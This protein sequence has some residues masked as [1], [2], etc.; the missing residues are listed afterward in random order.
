MT[1][2]IRQSF[3]WFTALESAALMP[4]RRN[5]LL[6]SRINTGDD[7]SVR[8]WR[9]RAECVCLGITLN[10]WE[11]RPSRLNSDS[12]LNDYH[13]NIIRTWRSKPSQD[14]WQCPWPNCPLTARGRHLR[15]P[16]LTETCHQLR[17]R[18]HF[19]RID[20]KTL[21]VKTKVCKIHREHKRHF[22][23]TEIDQK[24]NLIVEKLL[25]FRLVPML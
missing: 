24:Y 21:I 8:A 6:G 7:T 1:E 12:R 23:I 15:S 5:I 16:G 20:G 13:L 18:C 25:F 4:Q 19:T 17:R 14:Q 9:L 2:T 3:P 10:H 11:W 22:S